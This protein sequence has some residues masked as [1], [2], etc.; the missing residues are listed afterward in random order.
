MR[1]YPAFRLALTVCLAV[2][3]AFVFGCSSPK[4]PPMPVG[5]LKLGVAFFSQPADSSEM[6]AGYMTENTPRVDE[7]VFNDLDGL[8]SSV[9]VSKSKNSFESHN[10]ALHC[11][12]IVAEQQ[13]KGNQAA[14]R[15][16]ASIGRCMN[17]DLLVVPQLLEWRERDGGAMG[18]ATPAKVVMD[19]FVLDVRNESLLSRSRYDETQSALTNNLLEAGKFL[20]RGGKWVTARDLAQ[21]GMEKAVKELGL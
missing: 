13:G 1:I 2:S 20:K 9:L 8:F 19:I 11:S 12:K 16:W 21:E 15:T 5:S 3:V 10:S 6:L 17:V 4:Q 18:V 7:K 14:L